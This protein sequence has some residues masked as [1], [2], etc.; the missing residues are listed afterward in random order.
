MSFEPSWKRLTAVTG[1]LFVAVL[2][3]LGGRVALGADNAVP[4]AAQTT[5]QQT[6]THPQQQ[7]QQAPVDPNP[8]TTHS[9]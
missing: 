8:P 4:V 6:T 3:F 5:T 1:A 2:T 9:S 7:Q